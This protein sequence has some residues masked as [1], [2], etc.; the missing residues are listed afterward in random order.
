[1]LATEP[2]ELAAVAHPVHRGVQPQ[3]HQQLRIGGVA[4]R[5]AA[6]GGDRVIEGRQIELLDRRADRAGCVIRRQPLVEAHRLQPRLRP[7]RTPQPW[8]L[9]R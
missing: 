2:V 5:R 3:R 1:V 6:A 9:P 4:A 7:I 8:R